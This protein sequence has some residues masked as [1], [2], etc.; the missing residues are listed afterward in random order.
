MQ[1]A[2]VRESTVKDGAA[3]RRLESQVGTADGGTREVRQGSRVGPQESWDSEKKRELPPW[4][5]G[6]RWKGNGK[7][8]ELVGQA[9]GVPSPS[10]GRS[11]GRAVILPLARGRWR[12]G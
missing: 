9:C 11:W 3:Q 5:M 1:A 7:K 8:T 4:R 2:G 10:T 12:C 6:A